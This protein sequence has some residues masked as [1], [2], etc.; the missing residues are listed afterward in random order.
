[1]N[2][3]ATTQTNLISG[4]RLQKEKY[5]MASKN[6]I[7]TTVEHHQIELPSLQEITKLYQKMSGVQDC[8]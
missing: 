7:V 1:M 3:T 8:R 4:K 2:V 6:K 5:I